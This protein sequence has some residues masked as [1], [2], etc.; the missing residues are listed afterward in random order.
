MKKSHGT[1]RN[2][3]MEYFLLEFIIYN[4][5]K[6]MEHVLHYGDRIGEREGASIAQSAF[7]NLL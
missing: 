4:Y 2:K 1:F 7:I 6:Y 5:T 3:A